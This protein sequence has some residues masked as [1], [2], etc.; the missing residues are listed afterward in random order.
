MSERIDT[1]MALIQKHGGAQCAICD[2]RFRDHRP[3]DRHS[4]ADK[5][6]TPR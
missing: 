3:A 5:P 1:Y 2:V 6:R 4:F